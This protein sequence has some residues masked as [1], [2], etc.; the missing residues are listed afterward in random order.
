MNLSK[1]VAKFAPVAL[2][3]FLIPFLL[4]A[5]RLGSYYLTLTILSASYAIASLGLT[6]LLG[7][8][9]QISLA[10]AAFYGLGSYTI[11]ILTVHD[12]WPFWL[13]LLAGIAVPTLF[14]LFLGAISLR[15]TTH[16]LALVTIS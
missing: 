1:Q 14:G 6:V 16:Y 15:L 13:A 2:I 11:A 8:S 4:P 5:G 7:Y 12:H 9:G 3:L 10:Q